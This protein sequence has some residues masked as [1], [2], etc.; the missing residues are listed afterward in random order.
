MTHSAR[1]LE[2]LEAVIDRVLGRRVR[3]AT[4]YRGKVA[5]QHADGTLDVVFDDTTLES[6]QRVPIRYGL[7]WSRVEV[8][9]ETRVLV[10]FEAASPSGAV[11]V[12]WDGPAS[13]IRFRGGS[14]RISRVGDRVDC[15]TVTFLAVPLSGTVEVTYV[16][17]GVGSAPQVFALTGLPGVTGGGS[18]K[19]EGIITTGAEGLEA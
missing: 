9:A 10:A 15:G 11:V 18:L 14:A 2:G 3:Y 13:L 19:L 17:P 8:P 7:P 12:A 4:L 6:I 5:L 16:P 1:I